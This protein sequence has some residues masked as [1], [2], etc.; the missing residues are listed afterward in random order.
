MAGAGAAPPGAAGAHLALGQF[1]PARAL[2]RGAAA[3]G[4]AGAGA[5]AAG[6]AEGVRGLRRLA[7]WAGAAAGSGAAPPPPGWLASRSVPSAEHLAWLCLCEH[8]LRAPEE[9]QL[10]QAAADETEVRLLARLVARAGLPPGAPGGGDGPRRARQ[11]RLAVLLLAEC[12]LG[13]VGG[14][15]GGRTLTER[16]LASAADPPGGG[17]GVGPGEALALAEL[18]QT[19]PALLAEAAAALQRHRRPAAWLAGGGGAGGGGGGRS[20]AAAGARNGSGQGAGGG[21]LLRAMREAQLGAVER[22][23]ERG[24]RARALQ[25][26]QYVGLDDGDEVEAGLQSLT[27]R[28]HSRPGGGSRGASA[29]ASPSA[30]PF[31]SPARRAAGRTG[32]PSRGSPDAALV[33]GLL[34]TGSPDVLRSFERSQDRGWSAALGTRGGGCRASSGELPRRG[35]RSLLGTPSL[36]TPPVSPGSTSSRRR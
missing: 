12:G 14:S 2:L 34:A 9:Q 6:A 28:L 16:S 8:R 21:G 36:S 30:S 31:A 27:G 11:E 4:A 22:L 26:L 20:G 32:P 1:E 29:E 24:E 15:G 19:H 25:M 18:A 5:G 35:S 33:E 23:V 3:A 17:G 7:D 13:R 10:P